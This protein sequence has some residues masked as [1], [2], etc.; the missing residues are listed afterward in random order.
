[1]VLLRLE[2]QDGRPLGIVNWFAV[3]PTSMNNTNKLLSGD[4]KGYAS[5][6]FEYKMNPSARPGKGNFVA[7][8]ASTN[9][10][11]V[12]PNTKGA[13]CIDTGEPC[14]REQSTCGGRNQ[15]CIAF[16]PGKDMEESTEIIG[17][18][19]Y[20]VAYELFKDENKTADQLKGPVKFIHQYVD[21]TNYEVEVLD[22]LSNKTVHKTTCKG[23]LGYSF[24]AGTTDGPGAFDFVQ[25]DKTGNRFWDTVRILI[26]KP[27]KELIKCHAYVQLKF[28][29]RLKRLI[30]IMRYFI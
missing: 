7:A 8:F 13:R 10:G 5:M 20:E 25:G 17:R 6:Q 26:K 23:A 30:L 29:I 28:V 27:S 21:M 16:G 2:S 24:A 3:H 4:N 11:D 9:L 15:N 22:P 1:M 12:S 19:Q 14:D 18:K